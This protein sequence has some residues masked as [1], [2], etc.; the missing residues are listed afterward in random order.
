MN[1]G[2][3]L[4]QYESLGPD[5]R[6]RLIRL[7]SDSLTHPAGFHIQTFEIATAPEYF[8]FSFFYLKKT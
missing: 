5:N 4:F 3:P 8:F 1:A 6:I 2:T 7:E